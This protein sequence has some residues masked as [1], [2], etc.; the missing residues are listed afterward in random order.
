[1]SPVAPPEPLRLASLNV[2]FAVGGRDPAVLLALRDTFP[3]LLIDA[4]SEQNV[5]LDSAAVTFGTSGEATQLAMRSGAVQLAFL[6]AED[7]FPY[8][9]GLIVAA[10]AGGAPDLSLGLIV[11]AASDDAAADE[12]LADA[13]R[14]ALPALRSAL[15]SYTG[16]AAAGAYGYDAAVL[17]Q[18][19]ALYEA[20]SAQDVH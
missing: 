2:E 10:E 7:Y 11:A 18:L 1:M 6:P 4:L 5:T 19:G 12:R 13:L 14:A 8:R 16:E 20:Q 17:E 9:G 3:P 15:A